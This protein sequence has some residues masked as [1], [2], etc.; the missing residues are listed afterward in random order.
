LHAFNGWADKFLATPNA[1]IDDSYASAKYAAGKWK[2]MGVY[3]DFAEQTGNGSFGTE[4]DI[5]AAY[6]LSSRYGLLLKSAFFS[7]DSGAA[8]TDTDK[9]WI[10][11][12]AN[13]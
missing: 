1:G 10:K 12:T 9:F 2:F 13:Y 5:S 6:K 7:A 11:L 3:H 4:L 8:M